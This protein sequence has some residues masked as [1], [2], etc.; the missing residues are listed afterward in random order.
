LKAKLYLKECFP[1]P[2]ERMIFP[3]SEALALLVTPEMPTVAVAFVPTVPVSAG[4]AEKFRRTG[5][6]KLETSVAVGADGA[7]FAGQTA[8]AWR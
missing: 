5:L 8:G 7:L 4:S 2:L 3:L 1:P 6:S